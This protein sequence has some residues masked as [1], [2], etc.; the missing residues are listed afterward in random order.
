MEGERIAVAAL[1]FGLACIVQKMSRLPDQ[2]EPHVR[3]AEV[4]LDA[5]RVAAPFA[6][7][8]PEDQAVVA[9]AEK[10]FEEHQILPGTGRGTMRSMVEG[11]G[12][13][14]G[15]T[16]TSLRAAVPLPVPGRNFGFGTSHQMCFT[17][18]GMS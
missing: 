13:L 16:T 11:P 4:D 5:R 2:V 9:E 6:E 10:G 12:R 14:I 18:S 15:P 17:S 7:P 1:P 3:K 8:L